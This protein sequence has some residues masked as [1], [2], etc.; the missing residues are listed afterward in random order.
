M[1]TSENEKPMQFAR[2]QIWDDI[3]Q[4]LMYVG[5]ES[6]SDKGSGPVVTTVVD[7]NGM[8]VTV[9]AGPYSDNYE[10]WYKAYDKLHQADLYLIG[11]EIIQSLEKM[12]NEKG[13]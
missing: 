2:T 4:V 9:K 3:G 10:G 6:N 12:T 5:S 13:Q 8:F 7:W 11:K 1:T